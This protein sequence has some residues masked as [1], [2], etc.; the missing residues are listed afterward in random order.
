MTRLAS[1]LPLLV[2]AVG[3]AAPVVP[4]SNDNDASAIPRLII[5]TG[6]K[7]AVG[8]D[9]NWQS[10]QASLKSMN[11]DFAYMYF[12]DEAALSFV[13]EHFDG[14]EL[15]RIYRDAPKFVLKADL[16]RYAAVKVL[17][18]FYMDMDMMAK[19]PFEP[20]VAAGD[21]AVFPKEWW[22]SDAAYR[23]IYGEDRSCPDDEEHW[24][25][26]NYAFAAAPNHP[27]IADALEE[28]MTRTV[29]LTE[30]DAADISDD[31]VLLATGPYMLSELYHEGRRQGKYADVAHIRGDDDVPSRRRSYGGNDWHKF[32]GYAEHMLSHSWVTSARRRMQDTYGNMYPSDIDYDCILACPGVEII[33]DV[34]M[35][36]EEVFDLYYGTELG[37]CIDKCLNPSLTTDAPTITPL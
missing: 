36:E 33:E 27:F 29:R 13:D 19:A 23:K 28:A 10:Y 17:G 7:D 32:G 30:F 4:D 5:Q 21:G 22:R 26:G 37:D 24:Q 18:G 2:A 14:T 20:L 6:P 1:I 8:R 3:C 34:Y 31:D 9:A 16:F 35:L 25:V 15:P 11:P 12:D